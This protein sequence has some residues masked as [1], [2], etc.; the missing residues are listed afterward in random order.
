MLECRLMRD[1]HATHCALKSMHAHT[2][3]S[4]CTNPHTQTAGAVCVQRDARDARRDAIE[5]VGSK[6]PLGVFLSSLTAALAP[7]LIPPSVLAA[8]AHLGCPL[9]EQAG[10]EDAPAGERAC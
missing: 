2:C 5:R 7:S 6:S 3:A 1:G 4:A 9:P 10:D 8:L